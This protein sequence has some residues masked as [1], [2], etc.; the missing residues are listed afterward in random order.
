MICW[1]QTIHNPAF[2]YH[3][4][5]RAHVISDHFPP[6][7]VDELPFTDKLLASFSLAMQ[8]M[9]SRCACKECH[10]GLGEGLAWAHAVPDFVG[11]NFTKHDAWM[12]HDIHADSCWHGVVVVCG[13]LDLQCSI[14]VWMTSGL[15]ASYFILLLCAVRYIVFLREGWRLRVHPSEWS[16]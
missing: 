10:C 15:C 11:I 12:K 2:C 8:S 16:N 7:L 4:V 3:Y 9:A 13:T 5:G 14:W 6:F 1:P